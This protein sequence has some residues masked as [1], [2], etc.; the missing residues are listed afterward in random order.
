VVEKV[1]RDN[2]EDTDPGF[3]AAQPA[4]PINRVGQL[5]IGCLSEMER[6]VDLQHLT[7]QRQ[8]QQEQGEH[9]LSLRRKEVDPEIGVSHNLCIKSSWTENRRGCVTNVEG[10]FTFSINVQ[11][12][13]SV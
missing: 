1:G 13:N 11:I 2:L 10:L 4:L 7:G 3:V 6:K 8:T 12:N 9:V 5:Q